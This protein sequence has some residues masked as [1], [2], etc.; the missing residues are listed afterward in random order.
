MPAKVWLLNL[1]VLVV[2]LEADLGRRKIGWFRVARP[3]IATAA[4]VP[5]FLTSVPTSGHN[6]GLQATGV[7]VGVLLGLACHLFVSVGLDPA[8]GRKDREG[9]A[10]SRA[11]LGYAAFW[12]VIFAA[13]LAFIYGTE[14]WF[15]GS[16]GQFLA[17]HQLSG[18]GLGNAM[19]FMA[20][21]MA[22]TR[23]ALLGGRGLAARRHQTV[24]RFQDA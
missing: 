5:F 12:A 6:L 23:S 3:L 10:V 11:G 7:G 21:A 13:R 16:L 22:L 8:T 17:A 15:S 4:I 19:I 2:L 9:R 1:I 18:A 14:H 20:I 24:A